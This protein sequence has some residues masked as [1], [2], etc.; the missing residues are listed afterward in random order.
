MQQ[1]G[2]SD[3]ESVEAHLDLIQDENQLT[4]VRFLSSTFLYPKSI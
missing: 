1:N 2:M 4:I 3:K